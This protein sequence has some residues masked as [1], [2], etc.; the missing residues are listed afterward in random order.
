MLI[1]YLENQ[2]L[3]LGILFQDLPLLAGPVTIGF[4]LFFAS[5]EVNPEYL[6]LYPMIHWKLIFPSCLINLACM[7]RGKTFRHV[8]V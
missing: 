8:I 1:T 6:P 2:S 5:V 3:V 4:L 7:L